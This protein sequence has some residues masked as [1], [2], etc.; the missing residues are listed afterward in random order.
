MIWCLHLFLQIGSNY[1]PELFDPHGYPEVR[2]SHVALRSRFHMFVCFFFDQGDYEENIKK[3]TPC[4]HAGGLEGIAGTIS[5][6]C[7]MDRVLMILW[8]VHRI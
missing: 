1:P 2:H 8:F 6:V 4:S 5:S 3:S 7:L